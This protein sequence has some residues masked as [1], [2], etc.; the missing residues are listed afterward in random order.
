MAGARRDLVP[1]INIFLG[2]PNE[3]DSATD[4]LFEIQKFVDST[5]HG[6]FTSSYKVHAV[7]SPFR[8]NRP[9]HNIA[10]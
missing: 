1:L 5:Y 7:V 10:Q 2:G 4:L 6:N 3:R 9:P 8:W